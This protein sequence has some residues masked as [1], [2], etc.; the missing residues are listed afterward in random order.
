MVR[1]GIASTSGGDQETIAEKQAS[2]ED[3][4]RFNEAL[5]DNILHL[6]QEW[7]EDI[8]PEGKEMILD[9]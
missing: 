9:P 7:H 3:L 8:P 6:Q 2:M 5:Q 4:W 1:R